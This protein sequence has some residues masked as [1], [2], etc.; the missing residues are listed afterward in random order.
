MFCCTSS[1]TCSKTEG[2]GAWVINVP[3][4]LWA[5]KCVCYKNGLGSVLKGAR[6]SKTST[7]LVK[8]SLLRS[9]WLS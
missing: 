1:H 3:C 4:G 2:A 8:F 6:D 9:V 5:G 7:A